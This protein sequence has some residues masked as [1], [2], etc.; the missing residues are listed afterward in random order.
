M[1]LTFIVGCE[2]AFWVAIGIGLVARYPL[3]RPR[4]GL[5]I[6]ASVP[7]IDLALLVATAAHLGSGA[8]AGVEHGLAAMYIGF[9]VA[10]GLA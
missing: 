6:L 8:T 3:R 9:S 10:Y 7:F 4:L 5:L 1:I 2:I